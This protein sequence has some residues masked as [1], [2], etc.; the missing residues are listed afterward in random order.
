MS[1]SD[2]GYR[3]HWDR[4]R[5]PPMVGMSIFVLQ[6]VHNRT[7]AI[8]RTDFRNCISETFK[9]MLFTTNVRKRNF[10]HQ[11]ATS[12]PQLFKEMLLRNCIS[13]RNFF[14]SPQQI[15]ALQPHISTYTIN[16]LHEWGWSRYNTNRRVPL[17]HMYPLRNWTRFPHD[18]KQM[19]GPLD[20][21]NTVWVQW[22]RRLY[23]GL[24]P[25]SRLCG[26]WSWKENLQRAWSWD[27]KAVWDQVGLSHCQH[28][29]LVTVRDEACLRQGHNDQSCRGHQCSETMLTGESRFHLSTPR[30]LNLGPSWREANRW[31]TGWTKPASDKATM[32]NHVGVTNVAR[33]CW[34]ENP[35]FT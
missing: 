18:G 34:Q 10:F 27:R 17:S 6:Y 22:E 1:M 4:C 30:G 29:C 15:H 8:W 3:R 2:V 19:G 7:T 11:C 24:P 12:G 35:G 25:S 31:T 23:A 28:D 21:W 26:L 14:N 20:Q 13:N 5:C 32:I 9:E 16:C 33:Q